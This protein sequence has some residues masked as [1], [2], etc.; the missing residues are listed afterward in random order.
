MNT[1]NLNGKNIKFC[2]RFNERLIGMMFQR[3]KVGYIYCFPKC[4]SVHT[5][6]MLKKINI[7][8]TDKNNNILYYFKKV[9]PWR[10]IFPKKRV[11]YVYE[12]DD[13]I[14]NLEKYNKIEIKL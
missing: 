12:L 6:F 3:K 13:T 11:Y 14:D 8:M 5:F 4:N 1:L 9:K 7:I 10:I 2:K